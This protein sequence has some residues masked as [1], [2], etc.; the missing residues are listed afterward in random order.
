MLGGD[1]DRFADLIELVLRAA[2]AFLVTRLFVFAHLVLKLLLRFDELVAVLAQLPVEVLALHVGVRE[3]PVELGEHRRFLRLVL[4]FLVHGLWSLD[5]RLRA[6]AAA[7]GSC[8]RSRSSPGFGR[9][10]RCWD[11]RTS[12]E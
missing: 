11:P 7:A 9:R 1:R 12:V 3:T 6:I 4:G 8:W 2:G 10:R 5:Y